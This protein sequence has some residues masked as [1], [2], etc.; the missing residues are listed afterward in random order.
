M[1]CWDP[2]VPRITLS[3]IRCNGRFGA[4]EKKSAK[5]G[6]KILVQEM[7]LRERGTA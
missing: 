1:T 5:G 4:T 7:G 6:I 3:H 2:K